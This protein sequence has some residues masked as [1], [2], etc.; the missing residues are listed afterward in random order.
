M[1]KYTTELR[2]ICESYAGL[3]E[4]VGYD[5]IDDVI[6][7]AKDHIFEEF[8]FF[9]NEYKDV[10]ETKILRHYYTREIGYETVG[11]WKL[12]FNN[13]LH[14][15]LP[16]YNKLYASAELEFNPLHDVDY[17]ISHAGTENN[18]ETD[19]NTTTLNTRKAKYDT[20]TIGNAEG[21]TTST[22]GTTADSVTNHSVD[23]Y[24]DTPQGGIT[25]LTGDEQTGQLYLTNARIVDDTS[26]NAGNS[27]SITTHG[28]TNTETLNTQSTTDDTGSV[29]E[30]GAKS[31]ATTDSYINQ[32]Q[33]KMGTTSYSRL[34]NEY[35]DTLIN[36]DMKF[37]NEFAELFITLW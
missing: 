1:S 14:E 8:E 35:R 26:S 22:S 17:S 34:L 10:I 13:R 15:I 29:S 25:G 3:D 20:G 9:D 33:G 31:R 23:K 12:H 32:I 6:A 36:I 18:S 16:Y 7:A 4:S 2:Y 27:S 11:L 28:R 5:D 24:S 37:I 30:A 21:G 19:T